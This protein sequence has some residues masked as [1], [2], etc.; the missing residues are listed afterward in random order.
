[1]IAAT[2][3]QALPEDTEPAEHEASARI[4]AFSRAYAR[5]LTACAHLERIDSEDEK[6]LDAIFD[7][8]RAALRGLFLVP[9]ASSA[10]VWAKLAAFEIDLVKE[11][12]AGPTKNSIVLLAL[13]SI[14]AD[15]M[16]LGIKGDI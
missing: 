6:F 11:H 7:E 4:E 14:K 3:A 15:L 2:I 10:T 16:N 13:G 12:V 9:A 1:M 8:E 5:W